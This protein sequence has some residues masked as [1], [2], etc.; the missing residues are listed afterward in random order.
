M[1]SSLPAWDINWLFPLFTVHYTSGQW[2]E[3]AI[4]EQYHAQFPGGEPGNEADK[5]YRILNDG[6][7]GAPRRLFFTH[8]RGGTWDTWDKTW[9]ELFGNKLIP[10]LGAHAVTVVILLTAAVVG[11]SL[12]RRRR[13]RRRTGA[14]KKGYTTLPTRS[15]AV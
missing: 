10:W 8:G 11:L 9:F 5:A 2:F 13:R 4:W 6:R 7:E 12:W 15:E 14:S 3:T 1:A